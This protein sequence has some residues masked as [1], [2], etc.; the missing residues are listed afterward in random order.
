MIDGKGHRITV[1]EPLANCVLLNVS[2]VA[3]VDI[4]GITL[5]FNH[6]PACDPLGECP[7]AIHV[8]R[9]T[10]ITLD[11]VTI[12]KS[13]GT[14]LKVERVADAFLRRVR[15]EEAGLIGIYV[16]PWRGEGPD[17]KSRYVTVEE[18]SVARSD[19]NGIAFVDVEGSIG[20]PSSILNTT[21][22][23]NHRF[24]RFPSPSGRPYNG[25]QA[26][27]LRAD[28]VV[29]RGNTFSESHC[30]ICDNTDVWDVE[31][32]PGP[33]GAVT[34]TENHF[35]G[36]HSWAIYVNDGTL[37]GAP[38]IVTRNTLGHGKSLG[39]LPPS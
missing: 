36:H 24:G 20:K 14:G 7:P 3:N 35:G 15:V 26:Y 11:D 30:P 16:G 33:L 17:R 37:F 13:P 21:F 25:G 39:N 10:A 27:L 22:T 18:S 4:R 34:L 1:H 32:G 12:L 9:S 38:P 19:V 29:L 6:A 23:G 8:S 5:L 31:L 28:N 2:E